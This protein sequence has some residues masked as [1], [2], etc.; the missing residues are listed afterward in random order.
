MVGMTEEQKEEMRKKW[1]RWL[2]QICEEITNLL[3]TKYVWDEVREIVKANPR[4]RVASVF[5]DWLTA[6]YTAQI[7]AAIR[8]LTEVKTKWEGAYADTI[9]LG[10]MLDDIAKHPEVISKDYFIKRFNKTPQLKNTAWPQQL[11]EKFAEPGGAFISA[12]RIMKDFKRLKS[13]SQK[14]NAFADQRLA[15][16]DDPKCCKSELPTYKEADEV[17]ESLR[18]LTLKYLSL[19]E[20]DICLRQPPLT[21]LYDWKEPLRYAW[22]PSNQENETNE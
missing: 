2:Q 18:K 22:I 10:R 21:F 16:H 8:R 20:N 3:V 14:I 13:M 11:F 19:V 17:I 12:P 4:I 1:V 5:Y 7:A 15:H 6:N 9:S